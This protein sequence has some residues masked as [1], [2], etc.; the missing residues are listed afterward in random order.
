MWKESEVDTYNT[1]KLNEHTTSVKTGSMCYWYALVLIGCA[2]GEV[3]EDVMYTEQNNKR[4]C[5][6]A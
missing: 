6:S 5:E 3:C 2:V 4:L 1:S